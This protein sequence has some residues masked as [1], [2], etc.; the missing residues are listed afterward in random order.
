[1]GRNTGHK[2]AVKVV[3][4]HPCARE[5]CGEFSAI[6]TAVACA[7]TFSRARGLD[8]RE[9][10]SHFGPLTSVRSHPLSRIRGPR[11]PEQKALPQGIAGIEREPG[12]ELELVTS[13]GLS[14]P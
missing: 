4:I 11:L 14:P 9:T 2:R 3:V 7:A 5:T 12:I 8:S 10:R 1:M 6:R 13:G